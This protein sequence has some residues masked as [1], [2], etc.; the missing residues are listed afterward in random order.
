MK[1]EEFLNKMSLAAAQKEIERSVEK[2]N[3]RP[4]EDFCG[5]SSNQ[6]RRLTTPFGSGESALRLPSRIT[7]DLLNSIPMFRLIEEFLRIA[8]REGKIELTK[9]GFLK[10]RIL[11]ELYAH[12]ILPTVLIEDGEISLRQE[13]DWPAVFHAH[14]VLEVGGWVE[15]RKGHQVLTTLGKEL[16]AAPRER[17]FRAFFDVFTHRLDWFGYGEPEGLGPIQ[18]LIGYSYWL[19]KKFGAEWRE[20]D[21]YANKFLTAF[22]MVLPEN[23]DRPIDTGIDEIIRMARAGAPELWEAEDQPRR[24]PQFPKIDPDSK[25]ARTFT[26]FY[27]LRTFQTYMEWLG[28]IEQRRRE[29]PAC[30]IVRRTRLFERLIECD[31]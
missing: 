14:G 5:L 22:P 16:A 7:E 12:R 26:L 31:L 27:T 11:H 6:M 15:A 25:S 4:N 1:Y 29:F 23:R 28:L 30:P 20:T 24:G 17:L 8:V 21:F 2:L 3:A 18:D 10:R 19:V 13:L 9:Q